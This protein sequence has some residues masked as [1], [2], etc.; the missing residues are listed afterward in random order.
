VSEDSIGFAGDDLGE[1]VGGCASW[2]ASSGSSSGRT[3]ENKNAMQFSMSLEMA[4][5][6]SFPLAASRIA[7]EY[8]VITLFPILIEYL[9]S[10]CC[11]CPT[12]STHLGQF[13]M[14]SSTLS[15]CTVSRHGRH[16]RKSTP[17]FESKYIGMW[18]MRW[19]DLLHSPQSSICPGTVTSSQS[20]QLPVL[21]FTKWVICSGDLCKSLVTSSH[22]S[23]LMADSLLWL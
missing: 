1:V 5:Y 6:M 17:S 11:C 22:P 3:H 20:A 13:S 21:L 15:K 19:K 4:S 9:C 14:D 2:Y 16:S 18:Q 12:H 23:E 10:R 7:R 8:S